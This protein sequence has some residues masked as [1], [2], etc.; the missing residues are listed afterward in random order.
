MYDF[1]FMTHL[2][3]FYKVNLYNE[4]AK[5]LKIMVIFIGHGSSIRTRDFVGKEMA[6]DHAF[7]SSE[8]F[9]KRSISKTVFCLFKLLSKIR[10]R[11]IIVGG[12]DQ[13]EF[14][15]TV[16]FGSKGKNSLA[17][18]STINESAVTGLK[19]LVKRI[20]LSRVSVV[21][22]SG[23]LHSELLNQLGYDG[24]I[25][26]TKGVGLINPPVKV[27]AI[28]KYE[29]KFLYLGRLSREKNLA[30]LISAFRSLMDHQ[31]TI[32][33]SGPDENQLKSSAPGNV[34]FIP[35]VDNSMIGGLFEEN[36]FLILPSIS[37]T[38]GLV[39]EESLAH[40]RP[41]VISRK[42]GASELIDGSNGLQFDPGS[43]QS[44]IEVIRSIDDSR[45]NDFQHAIRNQK[46]D[47][48]P[49]KP[50]LISLQR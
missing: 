46:S 49:L 32:V 7:L 3:S 44:L 48:D 39:V 15:F 28:K 24:L 23:T 14:W 37:E 35:H 26:L 29:R 33:G 16:F 1:V 9:E 31:L 6:F 27:P 11:K 38:W 50:F 17:L 45:F 41:V 2:P 34:R 36:D 25:F 40:G 8:A 47:F 30:F 42:C 43:I 20:F 13:V 4:L 10:Y 5:K 22:A 12:W 19:G 21:Y 18:E